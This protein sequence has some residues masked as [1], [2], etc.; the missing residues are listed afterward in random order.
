MYRISFFI[1]RG[2]VTCVDLSNM[3]EMSFFSLIVLYLVI[4]YIFGGLMAETVFLII[5]FF[6]L[7]ILVNQ[8]VNKQKHNSIIF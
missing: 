5:V 1:V 3:L 8:C 4:Y 6:L 7:K 2:I